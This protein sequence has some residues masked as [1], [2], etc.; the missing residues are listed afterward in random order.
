M[1]VDLVGKSQYHG[2][3]SVLDTVTEPRSATVIGWSDGTRRT[4]GSE[5]TQS[6]DRQVHYS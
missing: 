4:V 1:L 2:V 6:R 3:G 5:V